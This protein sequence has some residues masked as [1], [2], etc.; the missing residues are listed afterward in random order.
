MKEAALG[1][2][3]REMEERVALV[4]E[5]AWGRVTAEAGLMA[6]ALERWPACSR[7]WRRSLQQGREGQQHEVSERGG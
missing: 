5:E 4:K 3:G 7:K 1:K 6:L 2:A